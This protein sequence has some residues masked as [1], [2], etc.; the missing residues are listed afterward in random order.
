VL[1]VL[2]FCSIYI[3][4]FNDGKGVFTECIERI[5][6]DYEFNGSTYAYVPV[7]ENELCFKKLDKDKIIECIVSEINKII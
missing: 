3:T 6:Q 2:Y 7:N 4:V 1:L 5:N